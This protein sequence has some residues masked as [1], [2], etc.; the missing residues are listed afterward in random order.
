MAQHKPD[1]RSRESHEREAIAKLQAQTL[2]SRAGWIVKE[3]LGVRN[4][5][6]LRVL[7]PGGHERT[8][9]MKIG[10][11]PGSSGTSA[12]QLTM[13]RPNADGVA[14]A[15]WSDAEVLAAVGKVLSAAGTDGATDMLLY[16]LE[17]DNLTPLAALV[18]PLARVPDTYGLCMQSSA[19]LARKGASPSLWL[20]GATAD[21]SDLARLVHGSCTHDLLVGSQHQHQD[22]I[23][24][25]EAS[26]VES[27]QAPERIIGFSTHFRRDDAV[28][29]R[30]LDRAKGRCELCGRVEF[31]TLA[32]M[33]YLESH[34]ILSLAAD[35]PDSFEN[36]IAL[37]PSHHREAHY[38]SRWRELATEMMEIVAAK[39]NRLRAQA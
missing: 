29:R 18:L 27:A 16:S 26:Q 6:F 35:G 7:D 1:I 17:N 20:R 15:R 3:E 12:V 34:H 19:P 5:H 8:L 2:L 21:Q 37:C 38:G 14:P 39:L 31:I 13:L 11:N 33:P 30:V 36:V 24:D 23:R 28:R 10:W 32:G 9:W 4:R 25:L 22:S